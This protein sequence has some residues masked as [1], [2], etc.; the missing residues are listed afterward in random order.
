MPLNY[1]VHL[2]CQISDYEEQQNKYAESYSVKAENFKI[3]ALYKIHKEFDYEPR[4]RKGDSHAEN[5]VKH[6]CARV[7]RSVFYEL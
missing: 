4:N 2:F 6:L 3:V 5:E 7:M 1:S